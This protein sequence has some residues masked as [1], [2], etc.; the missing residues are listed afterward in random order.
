MFTQDAFDAV[1]PNAVPPFTYSGLIKAVS[2]YNT[3]NPGAGIFT[4]GSEM[5]QKQELAAFLANAMHA[6][7]DFQTARNYLACGDSFEADGQV[8]CKPCNSANF[9]TTLKTCKKSLVSNDVS[10]GAFCN[11]VLSP[12]S[13]PDGCSCSAQFEDSAHAGYVNANKLYFGRGSGILSWNVS[14]S[15]KTH[16]CYHA[17]SCSHHNRFL[18]VSL[19]HSTTTSMSV[20]LSLALKKHFVQTLNCLLL[21]KCMFGVLDCGFGWK[22]QMGLERQVIRAFS[23][24]VILAGQ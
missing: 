10:Y 6:S 12:T 20:L 11:A 9:N 2:L 8:F 4:Q 19:L 15:N 3:K 18:L 24:M 5:K 16:G 14:S 1:A 21:M 13:D 17:L 22:S 7:D 23:M